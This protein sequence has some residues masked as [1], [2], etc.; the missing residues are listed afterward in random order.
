[1][2]LSNILRKR[3]N[4]KTRTCSRRLGLEPLEQRRVMAVS[5]VLEGTVLNITGDDRNDTVEFVEMRSNPN[6]PFADLLQVS[7]VDDQ[8]ARDN[9]Y[10]AAPALTRIVFHGNGGID[11]LKNVDNPTGAPTFANPWFTPDIPFLISM[12]PSIEAHGGSGNDFL[13]GGLNRLSL[14]RTE[15]IH[16]AQKLRP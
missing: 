5:L 4:A 6:L 8:G 14:A 12:L 9:G 11:T 1:M 10:F 15:V 13:Y 16:G 7:W 2:R 3:R